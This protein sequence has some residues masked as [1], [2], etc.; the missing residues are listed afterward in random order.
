M[1][2]IV[3]LL[4]ASSACSTEPFSS[5]TGTLGGRVLLSSAVAGAAVSIDQL[6]LTT[7]DVRAHVGDATTGADGAFSIDTQD[8]SGLLL[9]TSSGGSFTD[10]GGNVIVL[11]ASQTLRSFAR[12]DLEGEQHDALVSSVG[13]LMVTRFFAR[14]DGGAASDVETAAAEHL[15][16]HFGGVDWTAIDPADL[17]IGAASPTEP[18]RAALVEAAFA[19]LADDIRSSASASPQEVNVYTLTQALAQDLGGDTFDGNDG[20][21]PQYGDGIQLG[22]CPRITSCSAPTT[23]CAI[24]ACRTLCDLYAGT[25]RALLAAEMPRVLD[26]DLNHTGLT[27]ADVLQVASAIADNTDT[28]LFGAACTESLDRLPP[29]IMWT[30]PTPDA[31]AFVRGTIAVKASAMDTVDP[32]PHIQILGYPD[33]DGDPTNSTAIAMIDTAA[34]ADGSLTVVAEASDMSGNVKM[35]NRDLVTDNTAPAVAI[36]DTG[37]YIAGSWWSASDGPLLHGTYQETN[38]IRVEAVIG[39]A[40]VT[41]TLAGGSWSVQLPPGTLTSTGVSVSIVVTDAAGNQG[42]AAEVFRYDGT[43]PNVSVAASLVHDEAN[44]TV[45][46]SAY[47]AVPASAPIHAHDGPSVDLAASTSCPAVT[48]F[49]YLLGSTTPIFATETGGRNPLL[50]QYVTADDGVGIDASRTQ[51]RIGLDDPNTSVTT[52]LTSWLAVGSGTSLGGGATGYAVAMTS[53]VVTGLAT[54]ES[55]YRVELQATD[56]LGRTTSVQRCVDL[57]LRA[58]PLE[59]HTGSDTMQLSG[60]TYTA[61]DSTG[62]FMS[63]KAQSLAAGAGLYETIAS[64]VLNSGGIT[65]LYDMPITNGTATTVY[66]TVTVAPPTS[67]TMT[68]AETATQH[69]ALR[70]TTTTTT[71]NDDCMT[72]SCAAPV[73]PPSYDGGDSPA[74]GVLVWPV[75]VYEVDGNGVPTTAIACIGSC[76]DTDSTFLFAIPPRSTSLGNASPPRHFLAMSMVGPIVALAPSDGVHSASPPF[77][78]TTVSGVAITGLKPASVR[79]C[80]QTQLISGTLYCR[81]YTTYAPYRALKDLTFKIAS[82]FVI[83]S[84][85]TSPTAAIA[86]RSLATDLGTSDHFTWTTSFSGTL[87]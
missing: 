4:F 45:T 34:L 12:A 11:D 30:P 62:H 52:W 71:A 58:P 51:Y 38:P 43:P 17:S 27:S 46:F 50:Y 6:D 56:W 81:Q 15:N 76:L 74:V 23:G 28:D 73:V 36:D 1:F 57:S 55:T 44:E 54:T 24:G 67:G 37:F 66:L 42:Q 70:Y 85:A 32:S 31:S 65:S 18:V 80:T 77:I 41:G 60:H 35:V 14:L 86:P 19:F 8:Y 59:L 72:H 29:D 3:G 47:N 33:A 2:G 78:D 84:Y 5:Q 20:N 64:R 63:L 13:E 68:P 61:G 39:A 87:P 26:S 79:G 22:D 48:K 25:P 9:I 53:D 49:S 82:G 7:G 75:R 16:T 40:H 10:L 83:S 69:F 21:S